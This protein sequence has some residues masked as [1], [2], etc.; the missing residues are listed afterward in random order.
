MDRFDPNEWTREYVKGNTTECIDFLNA[1]KGEVVKLLKE[2]NYDAVIVGIDRMLNGAIKIHNYTEHDM[3]PFLAKHSFCQ[4]AVVVCGMDKAP[5]NKRRKV[6]IEAFSDAR[7]FATTDMMRQG[8]KMCIDM[9]KAG[10]SFA[11]IKKTIAPDF[12]YDIAA[13]AEDSKDYFKSKGLAVHDAGWEKR[14]KIITICII[15]LF[16]IPMSIGPFLAGGKKG[17]KE[18][19]GA[20]SRR[21]TAQSDAYEKQD[22]PETSDTSETGDISETPEESIVSSDA[23]TTETTR[24]WALAYRDYLESTYNEYKESV[25]NGYYDESEFRFGFFYLNGDSIPE[26]WYID[27]IGAHGATYVILTYK[28]GKAVKVGNGGNDFCYHEK[29]GI[30]SFSGFAG[31]SRQTTFY[32]MLSSGCRQLD[33]FYNEEISLDD[34]SGSSIVYRVNDIQVSEEEYNKQLNAYS[35]RYGKEIMIGS[36]SG[37]ALNETNIREKC[38]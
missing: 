25:Y 30:F 16:L 4:G 17:K 6:A 18:I 37:F 20:S 27:G 28:D 33:V 2:R 13:F 31:K 1:T 24:D 7:D 3:K 34:E 10:Q 38:K 19:I 35:S 9:L 22:E 29:N 11:S 21:D 5:D 23:K 8:S 36:G 12:P 14:K 32:E 15:L 26:L